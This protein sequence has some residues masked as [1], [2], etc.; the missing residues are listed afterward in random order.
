MTAWTWN[1]L[2]QA[3]LCGEKPGVLCCTVNIYD[4][5]SHQLV[6][7]N[8]VAKLCCATVNFDTN[9]KTLV[10]LSLVTYPHR[11]RMN[12][13]DQRKTKRRVVCNCN[14]LQFKCSLTIMSEQIHEY[15]I[16]VVVLE[17]TVNLDKTSALVPSERSCQPSWKDNSFKIP[18]K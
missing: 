10:I 12:I 18:I 9:L 11:L 17:Y 13:I 16:W 14:C 7:L 8:S 4:C 6:I 3:L 15:C 5:F 2:C 1:T